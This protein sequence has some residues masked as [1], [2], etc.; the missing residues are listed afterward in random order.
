[1]SKSAQQAVILPKWP[2]SSSDGSSNGEYEFT[3]PNPK[4]KV[5]WQES[6]Q[7]IKAAVLK[8]SKSHWHKFCTFLFRVQIQSSS[9]FANLCEMSAAL[10][11]TSPTTS[12]SGE[13]VKFGLEKTICGLH[14]HFNLP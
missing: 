9:S 14:G 11:L 13:T 4:D 6:Q 7:K 5:K 8:S 2:S 10:L 1:M 3:L 12:Q